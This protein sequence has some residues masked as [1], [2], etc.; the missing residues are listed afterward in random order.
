MPW[1]SYQCPHGH[2]FERFSTLADFCEV[3]PCQTHKNCYG[4]LIITAPILVA[5]Q[6]ECRYDSPIT[7][8]PI[9]SWAKRRED[10]AKHNCVPYDPEQKT[11]YMN[12]IKDSERQLDKALDESVEE[13]FEKLPTKQRGILASEVTEQGK[14]LDYARG[15]SNG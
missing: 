7:G 12:R 15:G 10:L 9:D 14:T 3:S 2:I 5:A 11:D 13:V 4:N 8:E 6:Q 1:Y